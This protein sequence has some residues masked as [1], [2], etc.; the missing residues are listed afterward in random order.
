MTQA[1]DKKLRRKANRKA[2]A[3]GYNLGNL[4]KAQQRS[5]QKFGII[6]SCNK[7]LDDKTTSLQ[8]KAGARKRKALMSTDWRNREVT[9][10]RNWYK[11]GKCGNSAVITVEVNN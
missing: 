1:I 5:E 9:N 10:L 7:I 11:P 8:E 4:G 3:L 2:K 6:A